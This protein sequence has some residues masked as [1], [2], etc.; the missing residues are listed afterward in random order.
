MADLKLP[1]PG[2]ERFWRILHKPTNVKLPLK[3]ELREYHVGNRQ[4][5]TAFS[6][7]VGT[8]NTTADETAIRNTADLILNRVGRVDEFVGDHS[9]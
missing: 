6:D 2:E 5:N 1:D 9:K 7:L 4:K 8:D 3:L